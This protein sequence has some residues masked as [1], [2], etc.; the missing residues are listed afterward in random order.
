[1][2]F[3]ESESDG[4]EHMLKRVETLGLVV[5]APKVRREEIDIL[6]LS[7]LV[8]KPSNRTQSHVRV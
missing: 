6:D 5:C 4:L 2:V 1:M 7:P 3:S 8:P